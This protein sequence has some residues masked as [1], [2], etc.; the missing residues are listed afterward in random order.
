MKV[1]G[2]VRERT[3][4]PV[5]VTELDL[6]APGDGE[7]LVRLGRMLTLADTKRAIIYA[8]EAVHIADA[9]G[10]RA[11][12]TVALYRRGSVHG[13]AG[14]Y[15]QGL[16][17]LQAASDLFALLPEGA[18]SRLPHLGCAP[19]VPPPTCPSRCH[20]TSSAR[21][22]PMRPCQRG[23]DGSEGDRAAKGL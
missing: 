2:A 13:Y 23:N 11:L 12:A 19:L 18:R 3:G 5:E 17:G 7:V 9:T 10:D 15:R 4:G 1:R 16:A 20:V 6:A 14:S 8:D 22:R 21:F